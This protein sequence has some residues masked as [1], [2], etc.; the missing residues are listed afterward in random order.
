VTSVLVHT[1]IFRFVF[2]RASGTLHSS[3]SRL[4]VYVAGVTGIYGFDDTGPTQLAITGGREIWKSGLR[5]TPPFNHRKIDITHTHTHTHT[6]TGCNLLPV[7]CASRSVCLPASVSL[8]VRALLPLWTNHC[9]AFNGGNI[10]WSLRRRWMR[11][12]ICIGYRFETSAHFYRATPLVF[13]RTHGELSP[14]RGST[15]K[16]T[17][18][19]K[20]NRVVINP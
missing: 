4:Y 18:N 2:H 7:L 14:S 10:L 19:G 16:C 5:R 17:E 3:L 1:P 9:H 13:R 15:T 11:F 20:P 6:P 12:Q 8:Q